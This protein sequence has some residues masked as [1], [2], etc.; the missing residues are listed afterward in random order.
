MACIK[1]LPR[2]AKMESTNHREILKQ[3]RERK[4]WSEHEAADQV[5]FA[6]ITSRENYYDIE[7][8]DG[9]L[10]S[11]YSLNEIC[12]LCQLFDIRPK[13]LFCTE[14]VPPLPIEAVIGK[15]KEHC[16]QNGISIEQFEDK[17]GWCVES[18]LSNPIAALDKWNLD[19]LKAVCNELQIDWRGVISSL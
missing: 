15:I 5:L 17:A 1:G 16:A 18:F 4:G 19:C 11:C 3:A 14:S 2:H 13:D 7:A 9:E 12:S 10:T 8:H 6:S